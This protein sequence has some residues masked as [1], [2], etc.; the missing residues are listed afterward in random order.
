VPASST[1]LAASNS[2]LGSA[3]I[4]EYL[5]K[6]GLLPTRENYLAIA[7]P[8]G[9]PEEWT[10]ELENQLPLEFQQPLEEQSPAP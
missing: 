8:D 10:Q 4:L 6:A 3:A 2:P 1:S 9:I 7:Y 5:Q